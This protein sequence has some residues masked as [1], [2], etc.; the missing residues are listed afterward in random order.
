MIPD[1]KCPYCGT[2][3]EVPQD[4][5]GLGYVQTGRTI[6]HKCHAAEI[7]PMDN[8]TGPENSWAESLWL[9]DQRPEPQQLSHR[10]LETHWYEPED[11]SDAQCH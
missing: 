1:V 8:V 3:C 11:S 5:I 4:S 2:L 10:E 6:C 7:G 9:L